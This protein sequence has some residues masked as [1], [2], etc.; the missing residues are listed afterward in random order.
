MML[1]FFFI[2]ED[3]SFSCIQ[4]LFGQYLY[5]S[6]RVKAAEGALGTR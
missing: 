1:F 3:S 4:Y 6:E 5:G 2:S